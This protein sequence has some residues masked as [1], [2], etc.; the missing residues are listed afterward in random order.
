ME[1]SGNHSMRRVGSATDV[2]FA[3]IE[4]FAPTVEASWAALQRRYADKITDAEIDHLF[5]C[6]ILGLT[7]PAYAEGE[8]ALHFDVCRALVS[9]KLPPDRTEAALHAVPEPTQ[10]WVASACDLIE[11]QGGKIGLS[12]RGKTRNFDDFLTAEANDAA[13][14]GASAITREDQHD[15][16]RRGAGKD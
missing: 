9:T 1:F 7:S 10:P 8:P 13:H 16:T 5:A 12:L 15:Q 11:K 4:V 3:E 2:E 14:Q 6:F